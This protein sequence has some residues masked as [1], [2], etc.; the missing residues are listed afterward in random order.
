MRDVLRA[1]GALSLFI[2]SC[3][4][5]LPMGALGLLLVLHTQQLTGSYAKG[6]LASAAYAIALALSN[7]ALARVVDHHG[8][9]LVLRAG[10]PLAAAAILVLAT[11]KDGAPLEAILAAAAVAGAC[12]PPVGACMRAL[13]PVLLDSPDRRHAAYSMEGALLE[14][15]YICGPVLIVAGIGSW[16]TAAAMAAC[17]AFLLAGDLAF[18]AHPVS[19]AWRP[20]A[21]RPRDLTGALRGPG[22]RVLVAVFVLCGLSIGAVEVVV[23]AALDATGQRELT[24]VLLGVWGAGSMLAGLAIG[25]AGAA[26][27]PPRRLALAL[28]AWGLAHAA[29]GVSGV[30]AVLGLLLFVA[31][32]TIAPTVVSA[33]GMLDDLA[34]VG[35][36]TEAFTWTSTGIAVGIAAGSAL[37]GALVEAASPALA[38]AALGAGGVLAALVVRAAATGPLRAAVPAPA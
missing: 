34:P 3:V 26:A 9:T 22:V 18:S 20:H 16:S 10:A 23:P 21:E 7:P 36:I 29:L 14:I 38:M 28:G 11:L 5:R 32:A 33:N 12:Q 17:A 24:G 13:W 15:V 8:Q 31:G 2:A 4:A 1:P 27:D 37:A 6:G 19:R 35:T 25:R 30:P